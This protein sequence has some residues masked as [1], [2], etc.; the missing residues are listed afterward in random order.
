MTD[1]TTT[2]CPRCSGLA[3]YWV[4]TQSFACRCGWTVKLDAD[5]TP[6][7]PR[8]PT[9]RDVNWPPPDLL[10]ERMVIM[11]RFPV[12]AGLMSE[13]PTR[14]GEVVALELEMEELAA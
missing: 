10:A 2:E 6:V 12:T 9:K 3:V 11:R 1:G 4:Q 7:F 8:P 13:K 14:T 5:G